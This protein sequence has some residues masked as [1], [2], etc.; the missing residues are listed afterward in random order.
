MYHS[1]GVPGGYDNIS[2][3]EFRQHLQW[4]KETYSVVPLAEIQSNSSAEKRVAIT[5]DDGLASFY[6]AIVPICRALDVPVT[7]FIPTIAV[8]S[9]DGIETEDVL[10]AQL[11]TPERF[12]TIEEIQTVADDPL[13]TVGAHT[14]T[15]RPLSTVT[16]PDELNLEILEGTERLESIVGTKINQFAYPYNDWC[17]EAHE[18]VR[19]RFSHAVQG[20]GLHTLITPY[21]SP[22][23]LSRINGAMPTE[24]LPVAL[25]DISTY[26]RLGAKALSIR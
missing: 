20:R 14:W 12:M 15:H 18:I 19:E 4:L 23:Q 2:E 6:E 9:V 26:Y 7:V 10:E 25:H 1:V 11:E 16:S 13:V 3:T 21:T 5:V 17:R 22:Q 8:E 24:H